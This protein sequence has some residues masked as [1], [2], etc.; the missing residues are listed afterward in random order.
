MILGGG[1]SQSAVLTIVQYNGVTL[2]HAANTNET[3]RKQT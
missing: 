1:N 3:N 2:I